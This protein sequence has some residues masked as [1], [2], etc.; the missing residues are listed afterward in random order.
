[1]LDALA[2]LPG[3]RQV[4]VSPVG[5]TTSHVAVVVLRAGAVLQAEEVSDALARVPLDER[6]LL[7]RSGPEAAGPAGASATR[8]WRLDR[9]TGRYEDDA[10]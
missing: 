7:V 1:M 10:G 6:P 9:Q 2:S 3:V 5:T 8:S 4:V